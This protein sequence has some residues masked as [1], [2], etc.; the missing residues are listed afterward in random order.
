MCIRPLL[1]PTPPRSQ[2][3]PLVLASALALVLALASGCL[4]TLPPDDEPP[5]ARVVA[6][7][8]PLACGEPHRVAVEL[9][10]EDG[11]DVATSVPCILGSLSLDL[12]QWGI[13]FGRV[14]AWDAGTIRRVAP[15]TLT[16]DATVI[17][18]QLA[19]PP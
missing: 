15:V 1:T 18:W 14:Y 16:I 4:S 2:L 13:Y 3:L 7:W 5:A 6:Q 12:P 9:E 17:H 19:D 10:H 11:T 8:D